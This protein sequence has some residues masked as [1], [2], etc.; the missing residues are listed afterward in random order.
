MKIAIEAGCDNHDPASL[1][2]GLPL[3]DN[4][5]ISLSSDIMIDEGVVP[6]DTI[7]T[8]DQ[9]GDECIGLIRLQSWIWR[10]AIA[11]LSSSDLT[12]IR[13][14]TVLDDCL[15]DSPD[16]LAMYDCRV[17]C[18]AEIWVDLTLQTEKEN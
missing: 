3:H 18:F 4:H 1:P 10:R 17:E 6:L 2:E 12:I 7:I 9:T 16:T 13:A 11:D 5:C 8:C 15:R 14:R